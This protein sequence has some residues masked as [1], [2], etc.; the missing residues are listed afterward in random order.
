M[1]FLEELE[2]EYSLVLSSKVQHVSL[3]TTLTCHVGILF[4]HLYF[5]HLDVDMNC[6]IL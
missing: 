5:I 4:H 2:K 6:G 3:R 1:S